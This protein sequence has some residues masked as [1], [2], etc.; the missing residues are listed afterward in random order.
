MVSPN[1]TIRNLSEEDYRWLR[2]NAMLRD[3]ELF[4]MGGRRLQYNQ[5][6][7]R[8]VPVEPESEYSG[9]DQATQR[10][11]GNTEPLFT[12][13]AK[14]RAGGGTPL[15]PTE[16]AA[17]NAQIARNPGFLSNIA[18]VSDS[19][20]HQPVSR[21]PGAMGRFAGTEP[22]VIPVGPPM[23]DWMSAF[24]VH[25]T[26]MERFIERP[27]TFSAPSLIRDP[28]EMGS[29][30]GT[31]QQG[32]DL[33]PTF[34]DAGQR[35]DWT[36]PYVPQPR[37]DDIVSATQ[38]RISPS[39]PVP[40]TEQQRMLREEAYRA[41]DIPGY[42]GFAPATGFE[43][44]YDNAMPG[45]GYQSPDITGTTRPDSSLLSPALP[46]A[47]YRGAG[48]PGG[49]GAVVEGPPITEAFSN[50]GFNAGG[51]DQERAYLDW[52]NRQ[53]QIQQ[54]YNNT[55][56]MPTVGEGYN[57]A[58]VSPAQGGY[59]P[60]PTIEGN[61]SAWDL[62]GTPATGEWVQPGQEPPVPKDEDVPVVED[63]EVPVDKGDEASDK[64]ACE[65]A[66]GTWA[67]GVC[68]MPKGKDDGDDGDDREIIPTITQGGDDG[69]SQANLNNHGGLQGGLQGGG[70]FFGAAEAYSPA[71]T[72]ADEIADLESRT[73]QSRA[74]VYGREADVGTFGRFLPDLARSVIQRRFDPL[75]AQYALAT[76]PVGLGGAGGAFGTFQDYLTG[77][78][79][80]TYGSTDQGAYGY[81]TRPMGVYSMPQPY[82]AAQWQ[83]RLAGLNIP[84]PGQDVGAWAR[85]DPMVEDWLEAL[86]ASEARNI[87]T[88]SQLAGLNPMAARALEPGLQ[89]AFS[90]WERQNPTAGPAQMFIDYVGGQ[91]PLS[92]T[93]RGA[94]SPRPY[95]P[96]TQA[97]QNF[98][99]PPGS[100]AE[101]WRF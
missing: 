86:T 99:A 28:F 85:Q 46:Q 38:Y 45:W 31:I 93:S 3:G 75:S 88:Q 1:Q 59:V 27:Q 81:G 22:E 11:G 42:G 87:I 30:G 20:I 95:N 2:D 78:T 56:V 63:D 15:N 12:A 53:R 47:A 92:R 77:T 65:Q 9:M 97:T 50:L 29:S 94:Y 64:R 80:Y 24:T 98:M 79:P 13:M 54:Y 96:V 68:T 52:V 36:G 37:Q 48:A 60:P 100:G 91:S 41:Q 101:A 33:Y 26:R 25:P 72:V 43:R 18:Q 84:G 82:S 4:D 55:G 34:P 21:Q 61:I 74:Y 6:L 90:V 67:N 69:D 35:V 44:W 7:N 70:Q 57:A 10:V 71:Q 39:I 8:A 51:S 19:D 49:A 89:R 58:A 73:R 16:R 32:P 66:G 23:Q 17:L 76:A 5:T 14:L 40:L 83:H 62:P